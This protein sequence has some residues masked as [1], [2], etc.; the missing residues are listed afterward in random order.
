VVNDKINLVI[1][2]TPYIIPKS[3]DL[4]FVRNQLS[5]LKLLEDKYTKDTVLRLKQAKLIEKDNDKIRDERMKNVDKKLYKEPVIKLTE[6]QL[7]KQRIN[8]MFGI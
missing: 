4:T 2:I 7:H 8:K 3:K 5:Q 1:I 6:E